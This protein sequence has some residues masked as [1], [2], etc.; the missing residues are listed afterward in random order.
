MRCKFI[1]DLHVHSH[2]SRA[3]SSDLTLP[4][5][6]R[7]AMLKGIQVVATGDFTHGGWVEEI[8]TYLEPAPESGL[9]CLKPEYAKEVSAGIPPACQ[10]PVRFLL[11][12]E[13]SSIY[14]KGQRVRKVHNVLCAPDVET[15]KKIRGELGKIGN[16]ESDGRPI[17]GLDCYHLLEI[18]LTVSAE[19]VLIPAHIWTPWFSVLGAL[20]GFDDI[21]ECFGDLTAHIF[22]LETGLSSDPAMN[23]LCS[24]LDGFSL[25]S[26]SD[27]HSAA[28]LGREANLF[29]TELSYAGLFDALKHGDEHHFLGTI[30]FYPEEGK[31]H[32]DGHR[33]CE[34][35]MRP[36]ETRAKGGLCP[37]CGK[38]VTV[39]VMHRV[40][41]LADRQSGVKPPRA[42]PFRS[43]L[44]LELILAQVLGVGEDSKKVE[45]AYRAVLAALG[46]ELE[47]L[48]NTPLEQIRSRCSPLLAEAI[49]RTRE[50]QLEIA[51]GYDGAFGTIELF[52]P[53]EREQFDTQT[54]F[55][56]DWGGA[57]APVKPRR[58]RT[59]VPKIAAE[60]A[61][62]LFE[63]E[64]PHSPVDPLAEL[65]S[66]QRQAVT[67]QGKP[68]LVIAGPGTGKTKTLTLRLAYLLQQ[69]KCLPEQILAITFTNKAAGEMRAR[70]QALLGETARRLT[71]CTFH[72]LALTLLEQHG[73]LLGLPENF[74]VY[75]AEEFVAGLPMPAP[76]SQ[77]I[78]EK[79]SRLKGRLIEPEA[80]TDPD[81]QQ[82]YREYRKLLQEYRSIDLDDLML[83]SV[84]LL[85]A[86]PALRQ[87]YQKKFRVVAI[88]E[89]QD[90][91]HAQYSLLQLLLTPDS[92]LC[93]IGDPDQAIYG[94][95]G[96]EVKYFLQFRQDFAE[97]VSVRLSQNYRSTAPIL[98]AACQVIA[99]N[100]SHIPG[101]LLP[102]VAGGEKVQLYEAPT[103]K[104]EAEFVV[105]TIEQ[106]VGGTGN[107]SF[108]SGRV[109]HSG[110]EQKY[111]FRSFAVLYRLNLQ[112]G[113]LEEAF[114]RSGM[115]YQ[116]V[117][118]NSLWKS[119]RIRS[120]R[121]LLEAV[122]HPEADWALL[123]C[124]KEL[125]GVGAHTLAA[126]SQ[127]AR[128]QGKSLL[129]AVA[130]FSAFPKISQ[131]IGDTMQRFR[132]RVWAWH[133]NVAKLP[134]KDVLAQMRKEMPWSAWVLEDEIG[135][136]LDS[137][138]YGCV[139]LKEM[140]HHIILQNQND[141]QS[142][143][144]EKI[145]LMTLHASKGLEFPVV[146]LV[147]CD[148]GIIP[149]AWP[150]SSGDD[151]REDSSVREEEERRLF[152]VGMTRAKERLYL[153]RSKER[154]WL[155]KA[156]SM[157]PS[158]H[159]QEVPEH[160]LEV[161]KSNHRRIPPSREGQ[162]L[163]FF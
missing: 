146:F 51:A 29:D 20:S 25:V 1:A 83:L 72:R 2:Y 109:E 37:V 45:S 143:Q 36:E 52:K 81:L 11:T 8:E 96:A 129:D 106:L 121:A 95:R 93:V 7:W 156:Q 123:A 135:N 141:D 119:K 3:T 38:P 101:D 149:Y 116:I 71:I 107:F 126:L 148:Q 117:G 91:N 99:H 134:V 85:Q 31:Y 35:R 136:V 82:K 46:P 34:S 12:A 120:W 14:K 147:G 16:L 108:A 98:E 118:G 69:Q 144:V 65:N 125:P 154:N 127:Y 49:R 28:K 137:L 132:E 112:T 142:S 130:G 110:E 162:Q 103:E 150:N 58:H 102:N 139:S 62:P 87:D 140:L 155:G 97:A 39:G 66:E 48:C 21:S 5:L 59:A 70:L 13:V 68:L 115:P 161:V 53:G 15:V 111:S 60:Q 89:Y 4:S 50:G 138:A 77:E 94:F 33:K 73:R 61:L 30:E 122:L 40:A 57:A 32:L 26:N 157:L 159:L 6:Y 56:A 80:V 42:R 43:T 90:V 84:R 47:V 79:I 124:L 153:V 10:Q 75:N 27:A 113:I 92:D 100:A 67:H 18:L 145:T 64:S 41:A 152:Y 74:S 24:R 63:T 105:H 76:I 128:E 22:A 104:A 78:L 44:G 88:D 131:G 9:Y 163:S 151:V 158:V 23:W 133:Q 160:L 17:L 86:E 55:F 54:N 19:V 114:S